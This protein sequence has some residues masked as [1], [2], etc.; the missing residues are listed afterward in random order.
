MLPLVALREF[1]SRPAVDR[2]PSD[3]TGH[4][5]EQPPLIFTLCREK[6]VCCESTLNSRLF[7][8][9]S[10]SFTHF[11]NNTSANPLES[12]TFKTKDLKPFRFT[13]FQKKVGWTPCFPPDAHLQSPVTSH[14]SR[15]LYASPDS[16]G[17][18]HKSLR[19]SPL[20]SALTSKRASKSFTSNTYEKHTQGEGG[21]PS[22]EFRF[23]SFGAAAGPALLSPSAE[24]CYIPLAQFI[25]ASFTSSEESERNA[26][27]PQAG[28]LQGIAIKGRNHGVRIRRAAA[29]SAIRRSRAP[30]PG[31]R[32]RPRQGEQA[33]RRQELYRAHS[34]HEN[35][36]VCDQQTL[37]RDE[38]LRPAERHGRRPYLRSDAARRTARAGP[39]LRAGH[40]SFHQPQS[41]EGPARR[42]GVHHQSGDDRGAC[43]A[44]PRS[45][46]A[47]LSD[48]HGAGRR[49]C[50]VRFLSGVFS[51]ARRSRQQAVWPG[52]NSQG[53]GRAESAQRPRG[54]GALWPDCFPRRAGQ[55]HS[56][57]GNGQAARK[58]FP[59]R[60]HRARQRAEDAQPAH[61]HRYLGGD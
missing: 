19:L 36:A 16:I 25:R 49:K 8:S 33:E 51:R 46:R 2:P 60:E 35:S 14:R 40:G 31:V 11:P 20:I 41:P 10:L 39:F 4:M 57:G 27:R 52:A 5:T 58:Y 45:K 6:G 26:Y 30:R 44:H 53:R 59:V 61:G 22:F 48:C 23:S 43:A 55:H 15:A 54:P 50:P 24:S 7:S 9:K 34:G 47:A 42:A 56:C 29:R 37:F 38:R 17:T 3:R 12:H 18:N 1:T 28:V 13:H 32:H 21:P